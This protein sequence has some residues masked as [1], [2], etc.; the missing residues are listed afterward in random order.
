MLRFGV[1]LAVIGFGSSV[2]HFTGVQFRLVGWAED[3]QPVL[4]LGIGAVGV[5]IAVLPAV[6]RRRPQ[7][8]QHPQ[9]PP[10]QAYAV[11]TQPF[12]QPPRQPFVQAPTPYPPQLPRRGPVPQFPPRPPAQYGPPAGHAAAPRD[13]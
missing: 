7:E 5:L 13:R 4:G 12:P 1:F 3:G 11:P 6:L 2:L 8:Q 9:Q 10:R